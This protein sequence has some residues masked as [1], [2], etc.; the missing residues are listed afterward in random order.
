MKTK[1]KSSN[2]LTAD[3]Q[4]KQSAPIITPISISQP[5]LLQL[6]ASGPL[7]KVDDNIDTEQ[8]C[9]LIESLGNVQK[10]NQVVILGQVPPHAPP[11]EVQSTAESVTLNASP[12]QIDYMA[13][14]QSQ[15][16]R[17]ELDTLNNQCNN[18]LEQTIIL[19]PITP[20]GQLDH[21]SFSE[22]GSQIAASENI[23]LTLVPTEQTE[24]DQGQVMHQILQ[25]S[26]INAIQSDDVDQ[27]VCQNEVADL[28]ENLEETVILE[29]TP[30][31]IPTSELEQSQTVPQNEISS[32]SLVPTTELEKTPDQTAHSTVIVEPDTNLEVPPFMPTVELELTPLQTEQQDLTLCPFV[33]P[34]TLS[35]TPCDSERIP[36]EGVDTQ[37]E[38]VSLCQVHHVMKEAAPQET[39]ESIEQEQSKQ[40]SP[41]KLL[42]DNKE[43]KEQ[44]ENKS[45]V[46]DTSAKEEVPSQSAIEQVPKVL[47]VMS[48]QELVKVRKR[49]PAR[50]F[51]FQ[52]YVQETAGSMPKDVLQNEA[53][54]AKRQRKKSHLVVKFGPQSK[55]KKNK[56]QRTPPQEHRPIQEEE[57]PTDLSDK[58]VVSQKKGGKGKKGRKVGH[59]V[60]E[61]KSPASSKDA[62]K[63]QQIKGT[64]KNKIKKQKEE[65]RD[66][67]VHASEQKTVASAVFKKKK[68]GKIMRKN[69]PK[70]AKDGKRKKN[71]SMEENVN[72]KLSTT[73]VDAPG[74]HIKQV[75]LLLLKGHKQPQLK[76]HK[77]DPS[78]TSGQTQETSPQE[79]QTV[80][81]HSKDGSEPTN[82]LTEESKKKV[83]RPKKNQKALS[84]LSSLQVS[85]QPPEALP[86]KTK[87]TRKRKASSNVETEGII[88]AHSKRA[89]ECNDCG[90]RFSE[91][92]SL[93]KHKATVHIV[94]SPGLTYTNGNV[95]EGV[96]GLYQLPKHD[97]KVVAVISATA[98]WDTEPEMG[99]MALEDRERVLSF[100]ALIPSPSLPV[101]PSDVEGSAYEGK[102]GGKIRADDESHT[103]PEVH[104]PSDQLK[105]YEI[106][107]NVTSEPAP[108]TST[109]TRSLEAAE[110]LASDESKQEKVSPKHPGIE[111][112]VQVATDEDIKEDL[113]LEVDLVTV[114]EHNERD[115]QMSPQENAPQNESKGSGDEST[116]TLVAPEKPEETEKS[117]TLQTVSCSTHQVEVKEEEEEVLVQR[118][119]EGERDAVTKNGTRATRRGIGC[120]KRDA[121]SKK[122]LGGDHVRGTESD[123]DQSEC[124][125]VYEEHPV[126][127]DLEI[128]GK[129]DTD[130]ETSQPE[131]HPEF[132]TNKATT[133]TACL[134]PVPSTSDES[135]EEQVIFELQSDTPSVEEVMDKEEQRE[136]QQHGRETNQS[137]GI[138]LEKVVTSSQRETADKGLHLTKQKQVRY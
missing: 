133:P 36:K 14:K 53:R 93:Q 80:P 51:I 102:S 52:G 116:E 119:K 89:L 112:G 86:T 57:I 87:T 26:E 16:K 63:V 104:L 71:L 60:A 30:A 124:Q 129:D 45:E 72:V 27:M 64:K 65:A 58:K 46:E 82:D 98:D 131:T 33:A 114:G 68:Q 17:I 50:A 48:A 23:E 7:Q 11:L 99:E 78:K 29:L 67:V 109:Q 108:C 47:N 79:S 90:E 130:M 101:P 76:V 61:I 13:L 38:T 37:I 19:E 5:A 12:V 20:D 49:K 34:E 84:L 25:Q 126:T 2:T 35:Q 118:K 120:L 113:L 43:D 136:G 111:S 42:E 15:S 10:V 62:T 105:K 22:L 66:C 106:S 138:I 123:K 137:P 134:P 97:N 88:T 96:S 41:E 31:L 69:Q 107:P 117:L 103:S 3:Q 18:S 39:Q 28:K 125:V 83:G 55:D 1:H 59:L 70:N 95:F 21:P 128:D 74:P 24:Q 92:S 56:K 85:R 100:P 75:S 127:S 132:E 9:R 121:I 32:S 91:V 4:V 135:A 6:E 73:S 54:P 77:L 110:S 122:V 8:I 94:E 40:E 44:L 115:D 81:Q